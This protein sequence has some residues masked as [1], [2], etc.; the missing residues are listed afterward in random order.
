MLAIRTGR[1]KVIAEC[2]R[3]GV[4]LDERDDTG[5]CILDYAVESSHSRAES[6]LIQLLEAGADPN[7]DRENTCFE[8]P[9]HKA[10]A[11]GNVE[12]ARALIERRARVDAHLGIDDGETALCYAVRQG[13][14]EMVAY[15]LSK[16]AA[17]S[18]LGA[19]KPP[20]EWVDLSHRNGSQ[21]AAML[22]KT[23]RASRG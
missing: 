17:T 2:I 21:I 18:Y 14:V 9:L 20:S 5:H 16:G 3:R 22:K 6:I 7:N 19:A 8:R 10:A 11:S 15:L 12:M 4:D 1:T 23:G 13:H